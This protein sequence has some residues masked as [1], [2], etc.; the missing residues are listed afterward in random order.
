MISFNYFGLRDA[1]SLLRSLLPC[2]CKHSNGSCKDTSPSQLTLRRLTCGPS[3]SA[4]WR[5]QAA[6][7]EYARAVAPMT[8]AHGKERERATTSKR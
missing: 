4:L 3:G 5:N 1:E 2:Y 8:E 7:D 6:V